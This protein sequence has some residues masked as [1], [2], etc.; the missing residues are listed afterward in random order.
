MRIFYSLFFLVFI[1]TFFGCVSVSYR[2]SKK[3]NIQ[4]NQATIT[5]ENTTQYEI[6]HVYYL[7]QGEKN[8]ST[9][10]LDGK[11]IST[12]SKFVTNIPQGN[13]LL[14]ID[15]LVNHSLI[16][17]EETY[18]FEAGKSYMWSISEDEWPFPFTDTYQYLG[19]TYSYLYMD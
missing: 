2:E 17:Y 12:N 19:D 18:L 6:K 9:D 3:E 15:F 5:I 7:K 8:W 4:E 16:S 11:T 14:K 10:I 1:T 13:Y